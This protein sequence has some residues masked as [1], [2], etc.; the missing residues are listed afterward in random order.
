MQSYFRILKSPALDEQATHNLILKECDLDNEAD[1]IADENNVPPEEYLAA[2]KEKAREI[3]ACAYAEADRHKRKGHLEGFEEG[4]REGLEK[5]ALEAEKIKAEAFEILKQA[6]ETRRKVFNDLGPEIMETAVDIAEKLV[7]SQLS[8]DRES[9]L[10]V[11]REAID[12]VA[13]RENVVLSV[14]PKQYELLQAR[15]GEF[16]NQ[17]SRDAQLRIVA[18]PEIKQ[19]GCKVFTETGQVD[20][21]LDSRWKE[22]TKALVSENGKAKGCIGF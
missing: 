11:A 1:V 3:I 20:A 22:I 5:A 19:G 15:K 12:M 16:M 18:D 10:A 14:S 2:A 4:Y 9:I 7:C 17:L 13:D 21:T 8:I 6:N